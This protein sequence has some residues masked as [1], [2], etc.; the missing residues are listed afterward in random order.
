M[1]TP[2]DYDNFLHYPDKFISKV[3]KSAAIRYIATFLLVVAF[4]V[5]EVSTILHWYKECTQLQQTQS[6]I[7]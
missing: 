5:A 6:M 4:G 2:V 1:F 7:Q 3:Q